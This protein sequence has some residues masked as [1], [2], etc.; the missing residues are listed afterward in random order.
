MANIGRLG[1]KPLIILKND[2]FKIFL[3]DKTSI[4]LFQIN[5]NVSFINQVQTHINRKS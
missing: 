3:I 4:K 1:L 5:F 2:K